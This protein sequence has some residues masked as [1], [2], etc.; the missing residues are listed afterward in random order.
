MKSREN[1]KK[2]G[3]PA[4]FRYF[5]PKKIFFRKSIGKMGDRGGGHAAPVGRDG[6]VPSSPQSP[7]AGWTAH[8]CKM[9]MSKM[10]PSPIFEKRIFPAENA[11][12]MPE[13]LV[14]WPFLEISSL[15]FSNFLHKDAY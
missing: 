9:A 10:W 1:A 4:Y 5:R 14:F 6:G 11:G 13:K 12:N 7:A 15:V 8:W 3:F 2:P